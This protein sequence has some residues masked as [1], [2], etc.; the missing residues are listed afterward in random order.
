MTLG[1]VSFVAVYYMKIQVHCSIYRLN[2]DRL[3]ADHGFH[4]LTKL[5]VKWAS[6]RLH[7][8]PFLKLRCA[9]GRGKSRKYREGEFDFIVG[10]DLFTDTAYVFSYNELE[11]KNVI[12]VL[13]QRKNGISL[14]SHRRQRV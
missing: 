14:I 2:R 13:M 4:E 12:F 6:S 10:Y 1:S 8:L 5:Q 7:G 11:D 9:N 3:E